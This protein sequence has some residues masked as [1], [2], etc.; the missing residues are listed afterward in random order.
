MLEETP[1][2]RHIE[3]AFLVEKKLSEGSKLNK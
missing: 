1:A 3:K 2:L